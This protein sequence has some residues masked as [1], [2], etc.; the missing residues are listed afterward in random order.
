MMKRSHSVRRSAGISFVALSAVVLLAQAC[1]GT[2]KG[3]SSAIKPVWSD[4]FTGSKLDASKWEHQLGNGFISGSEYVAGWGNNELEYYTDRE[5]NVFVKDGILTIR[6]KKER[7]EGEA[8]GQKATFDWT[9]ARL[10]TAGLFSRTY[11]RIEIR[12][13]LPS[14]QGFWPA[15]WMLPEEPASYGGWAASGELDIMEGKGGSPDTVHQTIHYGAGWPKNVYSTTEYKFPGTD[16]T[17][18]HTYAVE[19]VPGSIRWYI[20]G[21]RAAHVEAWWSSSVPNP[22]SDADL[23]P[24][25]APY[26]KPFHILINLAVGGNF[27]GNPDGT[28]PAEGELLVDYVRVFALPAENRAAGE[29]PQ[30]TYPWTK[31]EARAARADGNLV[32]NGSFDEADDP[33][34]PG[35]SGI[36]GTDFWT[37]WSVGGPQK[38]ETTIKDGA[39]HLAVSKVSVSHDWH[40]QLMNKRIPIEKGARYELSFRGRATDA[41]KIAVIVG[42]DGGDWERYFDGKA[43]LG[44]VVKS[45]RYEFTMKEATNNAAFV[46]LLLATGEQDDNYEL[47]FDDFVLKR[48]NYVG[49]PGYA[50]P[51]AWAS[52]LPRSSMSARR[53]RTASHSAGIA[54]DP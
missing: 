46:Q 27:G 42:Q 21:V 25:P 36:P 10:R 20:D 18:W 31:V 35:I 7:F 47:W 30:M 22:K 14:G 4:E 38:V 44:S 1:A 13:K 49:R 40:I 12:A 41:R 26:D 32:Y 51:V 24:W 45:Y 33:A 6:A 29:R 50:K 9:S 23:N 54:D 3:S 34:I 16:S 19:W 28:T 5:E 48:L 43:E 39:L 53:A 17:D 11:G 2:P 37:L 15:F 8:K 52:L